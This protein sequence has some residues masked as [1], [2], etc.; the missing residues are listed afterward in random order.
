MDPWGTLHR[1]AVED[2]CL[3]GKMETIEGLYQS[4]TARRYECDDQWCA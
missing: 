2:V 4:L 3:I 1:M